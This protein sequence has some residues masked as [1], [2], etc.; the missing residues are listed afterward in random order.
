[1]FVKGN[2][3]RAIIENDVEKVRAILSRHPKLC[4]RPLKMGEAPPLA[5]A[6]E[7]ASDGMVDA[8]LACGADIDAQPGWIGFHAICDAIGNGR[9]NYARAWLATRPHLRQP[10]SS[11]RSG[12]QETLLHAAA[13]R[14]RIEAI[15]WL[16]AEGFDAIALNSDGRTPLDEAMKYD[17]Q[18]AVNVLRPYQE[19]LARQRADAIMRGRALPDLTA[20]PHPVLIGAS[21]KRLIDLIAQVPLA[22]DRDPGTLALHLHAARCGAAVVRAHAAAAHVQALRVQAALSGGDRTRPPGP[23]RTL[24]SGVMHHTDTERA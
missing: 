12:Y 15:E 5:L 24:D 21:R 23:R 18:G 19:N 8:I 10:L 11:E 16:L 6:L 22:A 20:G 7:K 13:R 9:L 2:L 4:N 17:R 1:M 14:G 3:K